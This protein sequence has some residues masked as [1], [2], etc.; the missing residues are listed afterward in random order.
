MQM[1]EERDWEEPLVLLRDISAKVEAYLQF[2]GE[3]GL[4]SNT[5]YAGR[6]IQIHAF[7][8]FAPPVG[9]RGNAS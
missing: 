5:S 8:Q 7:F 3:G 6:P 2:I 1:F 4:A 9:T